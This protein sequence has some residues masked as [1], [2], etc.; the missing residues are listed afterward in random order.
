[1]VEK[2][3]KGEELEEDGGKWSIFANQSQFD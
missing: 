1:M 2:I 3:K